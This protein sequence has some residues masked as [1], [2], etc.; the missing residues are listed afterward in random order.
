MAR[1]TRKAIERRARALLC[2]FATR[3]LEHLVECAA[4]I[5]RR[6]F[7]VDR[8]I[9]QDQNI[10]RIRELLADLT[11]LKRAEQ[12]DCHARR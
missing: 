7:D 10:T 4:A 6:P 3:E 5:D 8:A 2:D 11:T 1:S 12:G 9:E